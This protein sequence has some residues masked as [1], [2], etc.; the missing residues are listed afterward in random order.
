M[1]PTHCI[2]HQGNQCW[3]PQG[4]PAPGHALSTKASL[5]KSSHLKRSYEATSQAD[6]KYSHYK[7][8]NCNPGVPTSLKATTSGRPYCAQ[9]HNN[10]V[11]DR[12]IAP[13]PHLIQELDDNSIANVFCFGAFPDKLLGVVYNNCNGNFPYM[14]LDGNICFL[15]CTTT[16]QMQS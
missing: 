6:L 3:I 14:L 16:R 15:S 5:C 2:P 7:A 1:Q 12:I 8:H 9:Q 11:D 10:K 4:C 13:P